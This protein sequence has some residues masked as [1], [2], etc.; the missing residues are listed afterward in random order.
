MSNYRP[1]SLLTSFFKIFETVIYNRLQF[2][3]Y[4]DNIIA[5]EQY[6]FR[7]NSSTKLATYNLMNDI[8][9]ALDN[10]LI[11]GGLSCNLTK[12]FDCV[13]HDIVLGK[14]EHYGINN[15]QVIS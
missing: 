15:K 12:A 6:G 8:F 4:S 2:H 1:I 5:Q 7:T 9:T 11:V 3:I 14:L 10:K 13:K